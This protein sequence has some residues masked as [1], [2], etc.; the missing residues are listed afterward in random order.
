MNKTELLQELRDYLKMVDND[1]CLFDSCRNQYFLLL[2][3]KR[4]LIREEI[5]ALENTG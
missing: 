2:S 5:K 4:R 1:L 3:E